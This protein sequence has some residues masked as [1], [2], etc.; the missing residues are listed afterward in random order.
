MIDSKNKKG[1]VW[2]KLSYQRYKKHGQGQQDLAQSMANMELSDDSM[3]EPITEEEL[4]SI[5]L[6]FRTC[7]VAKERNDLKVKLRKTVK[8]R[9]EMIKK[10]GI[11]F[12]EVFPFYFID[13]SFVSS[14][15]SILFR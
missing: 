11:Q 6:F 14:L 8:Q 9:E 12:F 10:K 5:M 1:L 13:P 3:S 2:N 7:I 15:T 4:K